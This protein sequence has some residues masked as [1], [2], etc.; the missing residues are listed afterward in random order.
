MAKVCGCFNL[1]MVL[2]DKLLV[3]QT[4]ESFKKVTEPKLNCTLNMDRLSRLY[5][6]EI[7][8]LVVFS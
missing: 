8:T 6:F 4:I 2:D 1:S 3:H 5:D 7:E